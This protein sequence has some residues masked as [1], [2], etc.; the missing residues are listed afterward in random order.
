MLLADLRHPLFSRLLAELPILSFVLHLLFLPPQAQPSP[1]IQ[2]EAVN[3]C[4]FSISDSILFVSEYN[5]TII[6]R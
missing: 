4:E 3:W 2:F 1:R 6:L 5:S